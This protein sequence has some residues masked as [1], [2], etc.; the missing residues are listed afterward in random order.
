MGGATQASGDTY[1]DS[2]GDNYEI[3]LAITCAVACVCL[4]KYLIDGYRGRECPWQVTYIA[5]ME[6]CVYM[7]EICAHDNPAF[8]VSLA[9]GTTVYWV[10]Y[11]GWLMTTPV[12]LIHLSALPEEDESHLTKGLLIMVTSNQAQLVFG[13]T[14]CF[15]QDGL[16]ILM[17]FLSSASALV[18]YVAAFNLYKEALIIYPEEAK[19][20]LGTMCFLFFT[21]WTLF[22]IFFA[23]GPEGFGQITLSTSVVLHAVNDLF[24]KNLWGYLAYDVRSGVLHDVASK[25][26]ISSAQ[27][28]SY[29]RNANRAVQHHFK[30][31][32][33]QSILGNTAQM[34]LNLVLNTPS[35]KSGGGQNEKAEERTSEEKREQTDNFPTAPTKSSDEN[36]IRLWVPSYTSEERRSRAASFDAF[37]DLS[38]ELNRNDIEESSLFNI[39]ASLNWKPNAHRD[40]NLATKSPVSGKDKDTAGEQGGAS[41]TIHQ[42]PSYKV[43]EEAASSLDVRVA[44]PSSPASEDDAVSELPHSIAVLD[45]VENEDPRESPSLTSDDDWVPLAKVT[46]ATQEGCKHVD[47]PKPLSPREE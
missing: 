33:A 11:A 44:A 25:M 41:S 7:A 29:R 47:P 23:L 17:I 6:V 22:P 8:L 15:A 31:W 37:S 13:I 21:T 34:E 38:R 32:Q 24:A 40:A 39:G 26:G 30:Q 12:I 20:K 28:I 16:K 3:F 5:A 19:V 2:V 42:V 27:Y 14:A 9:N 46:E 4:I 45:K 43:T 10:R 1:F 35:V 36:N 18:L